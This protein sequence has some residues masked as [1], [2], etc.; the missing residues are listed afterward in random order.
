MLLRYI[1]ILSS[2][3]AKIVLPESIPFMKETFVPR[4]TDT[5]MYRVTLQDLIKV[6]KAGSAKKMKLPLMHEWQVSVSHK[7]VTSA[8]APKGR[9]VLECDK[10]HLLCGNTRVCPKTQS[11]RCHILCQ[12]VT[13]HHK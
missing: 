4:V 9:Q 3:H 1:S 13:L 10:T 6:S 2:Y 8:M 11:H 7:G 5:C 12:K